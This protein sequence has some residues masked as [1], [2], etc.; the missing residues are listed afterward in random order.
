MRLEEIRLLLAGLT[1]IGGVCVALFAAREGLLL[2]AVGDVADSEAT[3]LRAALVAAGFA[4]F[5]RA[6]S[7]LAIGPAETITIETASHTLHLAGHGEYLL[8]VIAERRAD[9]ARVRWEMRRIAQRLFGIVPRLRPHAD[10]P[11]RR[12]NA[13][14]P[15]S[16]PSAS[17]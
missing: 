16:R 17:R 13:P 9:P 10:S 11:D 7:Q 14:P 2:A 15:Q 6:I 1:E 5:D 8:A 4:S 3:E 12:Q